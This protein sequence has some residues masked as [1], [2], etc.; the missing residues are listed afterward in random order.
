MKTLKEK[1]QECKRLGNDNIII[2]HKYLSTKFSSREQV[3]SFLKNQGFEKEYVKS[4][5]ENDFTRNMTSGYYYSMKDVCAFEKSG[6]VL[7]AIFYDEFADKLIKDNSVYT[8]T[9]SDITD[10]AR[11]N[12][13]R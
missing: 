6:T 11:E 7:M 9:K 2:A 1:I 5:P 13:G 4:D 10:M 12:D 8:Q 3:E